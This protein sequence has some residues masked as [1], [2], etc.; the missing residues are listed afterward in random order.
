MSYAQICFFCLS[1]LCC[2]QT[3]C[4]QFLQFFLVKKPYKVKNPTVTDHLVFC[5]LHGDFVI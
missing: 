2:Q 3:F 1:A 5:L 4:I